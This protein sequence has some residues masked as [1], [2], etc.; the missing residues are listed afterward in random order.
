MKE[1]LTL[2]KECSRIH[3]S[4][5]MEF[6]D[7][8]HGLFKEVDNGNIGVSY[9][10][11]FPNFAIFKYTK[12]CFDNK[13]WNKF[14]LM[15]RGLILNLQDK[16]VVS[17]PYI[18]FFSSDEIGEFKDFIEDDFTVTENMDGDLGVLTFFEGKFRMA[19][20]DSFIA[21]HAEWA[22]KW[23]EDKTVL[24]HIDK[25]NTYL[26]EIIYPENK[27]IV[28]YNFSELILLGI[29]DQYGLEYDCDQ[30]HKE[31]SYM[32]VRH[33]PYYNFDDMD[34]IIHDAKNLDHNNKGYVVRFKSG[35]RIEITGSEY[36]RMH[37]LISRLT[38]I[39]IWESIHDGKDMESVKKDL[40]EDMKLDFDN[41]SS[42]IIKKLDDFIQE[43]EALH[44]KTKKM[45]DKDLGKLL[46]VGSDIF[47]DRKFKETKNYIFLMRNDKFYDSLRE[48]GSV[49]RR[50]IFNAFR[51][52][53]NILEGYVPRSEAIKYVDTGNRGTSS[54]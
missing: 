42:I 5:E 50:V 9:H 6:T 49:S 26:F 7:L 37:K 33:A 48:Y 38:P 36:D 52:T 51:P 32:D 14:T 21:D 18:K 13:A 31:A 39:N 15:A 12:K 41:I 3:P 25:T 10:P 22:D 34:S 40:P 35:L 54:E 2:I 11:D 44:D 4:R 53:S 45:T 47:K 1:F 29:F 30:I 19:T 27:S 16:L 43:V 8:T 20:S 24:D 46:K 28:D 17:N 23:I